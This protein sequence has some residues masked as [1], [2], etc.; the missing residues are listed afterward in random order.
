MG[1]I[2]LYVSVI[3]LAGNLSTTQINNI[4]TDPP[5]IFQQES[6]IEIAMELY[7]EL[8]NSEVDLL[9]ASDTAF[10]TLMECEDQS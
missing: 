10:M 3:F 9:T 6:C 1:K 4:D 5:G 8:I 2:L 7:D